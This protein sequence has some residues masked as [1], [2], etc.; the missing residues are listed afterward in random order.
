MRTKLMALL[1]VTGGALLAAPPISIG[2]RIGNPAP[3][4]VRDYRE[5][6]PL[7]PGPGYLWIEGYYDAYDNWIE[8]YWELPPYSGAYWV[9]PRRLEGRFIAGYWGGR[10]GYGYGNGHGYRA[11]APPPPARFAPRHEAPRY[12]PESRGRG[13]E[14]RGRDRGREYRGNGRR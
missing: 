10:S 7:C 9:A 12:A 5:Y 3:V 13:G 4:M 2:V 11:P 6:R 8:G 1:V 14:D